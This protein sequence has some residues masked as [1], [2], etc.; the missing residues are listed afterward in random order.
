MLNSKTLFRQNTDELF[1]YGQS[2]CIL[3]YDEPE[4][5]YL[6][7][8]Y[9][10]IYTYEENPSKDIIKNV[11]SVYLFNDEEMPLSL[12]P[13][14]IFQAESLIELC[15]DSSFLLDSRLYDSIWWSNLKSLVIN[16]TINFTKKT[17]TLDCKDLNS[18]EKLVM[19]DPVCEICN[20]FSLENIEYLIINLEGK[21][22]LYL[23]NLCLLKSL[24]FLTLISLD[25]KSNIS[26]LSK[27]NLVGLEIVYHENAQQ[28]IPDY[29]SMQNLKYLHVNNTRSIFD[30][31]KISSSSSLTE[32]LLWNCKKIK[33][34]EY[35]LN[36][37]KLKSLEILD[38][39][40]KLLDSTITNLKAKKL[41][42]ISIDNN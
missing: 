21:G 41:A 17:M 40:P 7:K 36:V 29:I 27:I 8:D 38:C 31:K 2:V 32:I 6:P 37:Q 30:I 19:Q 34:I 12:I 14:W 22:D 16:K 35:L 5:F 25:S 26:G 28:E 33:N 15:V 18:L 23:D 20:L 9:A 1:S 3:P 10:R 11:K 42:R 13:E 39:K 24:N 4:D